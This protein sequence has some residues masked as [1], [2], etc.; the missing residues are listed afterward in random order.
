MLELR[1]PQINE[2]DF[3]RQL[4]KDKTTMAFNISNGGTVDFPKKIWKQWYQLWMNNEDYYYAY[5]YDHDIDQYIGEVSYYFEPEY[6]E[7]VLNIIIH[8]QFRKCGKGKEAIMMLCQKAKENG[9]RFL[10]DD[11]DIDNPAINMFKQ[12]GF[13]ETWQ[14][15]HI[16]MLKKRL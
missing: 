8:A 14:K 7:Y 11:I 6:N 10:C 15:D 9:I 12:L 13:K 3:R 5:I 2:L 4:L 1:K 16:I